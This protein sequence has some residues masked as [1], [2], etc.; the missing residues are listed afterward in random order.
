MKVWF[1]LRSS[2]VVFLFKP[3]HSAFRSLKKRKMLLDSLS[4][5]SKQLISQEPNVKA[6]LD[7]FIQSDVSEARRDSTGVARGGVFEATTHSQGDKLTKRK[8]QLTEVLDLMQLKV[9]EVLIARQ[10]EEKTAHRSIVFIGACV[11]FIVL[12]SVLWSVFNSGDHKLLQTLFSGAGSVGFLAVLYFP[13]KKLLQIA[14]DRSLLM[15]LPLTFKL[16]VQAADSVEALDDIGQDIRKELRS[17]F[18]ADEDVDDK[19]S[20]VAQ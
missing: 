8:Q 14:N 7:A 16:Q 5:R 3:K 12:L 13:V 2:C 20:P 10:A 11:L 15:L 17:I 4:D 9:E 6:A 19:P 18:K 1:K